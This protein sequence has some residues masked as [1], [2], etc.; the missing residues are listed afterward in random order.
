M[1]TC[2]S[3]SL[4]PP[5][6]RAGFH[7][8]TSTRLLCACL[9]NQ[10]GCYDDGGAGPENGPGLCKLHDPLT[11]LCVNTFS[12]K[13]LNGRHIHKDYREENTVQ[14]WTHCEDDTTSSLM[15]QLEGS[16]TSD[17]FLDTFPQQKRAHLDSFLC[18]SFEMHQMCRKR[19]SCEI[20]NNLK[21]MLHVPLSILMVI[22]PAGNNSENNSALNSLSINSHDSI[23]RTISETSLSL[24]GLTRVWEQ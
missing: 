16:S 11:A 15:G 1:A 10:Q 4:A 6:N 7:H 3:L 21:N 18:S 23:L 14:R 12:G 19:R 17:I 8:R 2:V 5:C 9:I 22:W 13:R 20:L 24:R